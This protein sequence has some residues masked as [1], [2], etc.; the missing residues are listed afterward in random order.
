MEQPLCKTSP[1]DPLP[2]GTGVE[3][4][5]GHFKRAPE[6][7]LQY[8]AGRDCQSLGL[9]TYGKMGSLQDGPVLRHIDGR[10]TTQ[11]H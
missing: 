11:H 8:R 10:R 5:M 7:P 6:G 9:Y 2:L 1:Y 3:K 4:N